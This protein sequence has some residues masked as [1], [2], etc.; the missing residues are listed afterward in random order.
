[1]K[2]LLFIEGHGPSNPILQSGLP[3]TLFQ[4]NK[5]KQRHEHVFDSIEEFNAKAPEILKRERSWKLFPAIE[6]REE[7]GAGSAEQSTEEAAP[8]TSGPLVPSGE[9]STGPDPLEE[10]LLKSAELLAKAE[11]ERD[12]ARAEIARLRKQLAQ[13]PKPPAKPK[14]ALAAK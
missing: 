1:M 11:A 2:A 14:P 13:K 6:G 4:W 12:E 8:G 3:P 5:A 7:Q 9:Q 10:A